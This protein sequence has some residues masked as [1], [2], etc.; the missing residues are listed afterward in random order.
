MSTQTRRPNA[1]YRGQVAD[2]PNDMW[3]AGDHRFRFLPGTAARL[4]AKEP[5][6]APLFVDPGRIV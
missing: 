1:K 3:A 4:A 6:R 2:V 5:R